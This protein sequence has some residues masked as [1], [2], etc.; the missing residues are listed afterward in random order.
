MPNSTTTENRFRHFA[1]FSNPSSHTTIPPL[2][3]VSCNILP[4]GNDLVDGTK[5]R[6]PPQVG[7]PGCVGRWHHGGRVRVACV[8]LGYVS[9][10]S[11][12]EKPCVVFSCG[13][14]PPMG[15]TA[16]QLT[17]AYGG[18][19]SMRGPAE[20]LSLRH[21]MTFRYVQPRPPSARRGSRNWEDGR[22]TGKVFSGL[23]RMSEDSGAGTQP[24]SCGPQEGI[25]GAS[26]D[27]SGSGRGPGSLMSSRPVARR[28]NRYSG[29]SSGAGDGEGHGYLGAYAAVAA[30]SQESHLSRCA[31]RRLR[32]QPLPRLKIAPPPSSSA[33]EA[34]AS[35]S[36]APAGMK[37][38]PMPHICSHR[39]AQLRAAA[40]GPAAASS[41][42]ASRSHASK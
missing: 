5:L 21:P 15:G 26:L 42:A 31:M 24:G 1:V 7:L 25:P 8:L 17:A 4:T 22:S 40:G 37:R 11:R 28:R 16:H 41:R 9:I 3:T 32:L 29:S 18:S 19:M 35:L 10:L 6:N 39:H 36:H 23:R 2:T 34:K 20:H 12:A 38:A 33:A 13:A 14:C 30:L 27:S